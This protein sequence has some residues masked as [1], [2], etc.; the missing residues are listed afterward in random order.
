MLAHVREWETE[1]ER[2]ASRDPQFWG[3]AS[4]SDSAAPQHRGLALRSPSAD[5][6][7]PAAELRAGGRASALG[8]DQGPAAQLSPN[9]PPRVLHAAILELC[10]LQETVLGSRS[11]RASNP[12][13][14]WEPRCVAG[15]W[16][17]GETQDSRWASEVGVPGGLC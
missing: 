6:T 14:S 7:A 1:A 2:G 10:P 3:G 12:E 17:V 5:T 16:E 4:L 9:G 8:A 13:G 11:S 15:Q